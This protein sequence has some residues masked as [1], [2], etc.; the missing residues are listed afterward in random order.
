MW[1]YFLSLTRFGED[2]RLRL[3][4]FGGPEQTHLAYDG[5]PKSVIDGGLTGNADKD[6]RFNPLTYPNELDNF[7]QPHLQVLHD[8]AID[9]STQ[10]SQ[11][12][13]AGNGYYASSEATATSSSTASPTWSCPTGP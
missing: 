5:I 13:F 8:L 12:F 3:V 1:N 10:L 4:L 9:P 6:R 7:Y 11:T 2:S